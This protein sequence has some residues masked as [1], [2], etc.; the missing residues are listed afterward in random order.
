MPDRAI[1]A[2]IFD[3]QGICS[4]L[5]TFPKNR[6]STIFGGHLEFLH[7]DQ[8][9]IYLGNSGRNFSQRNFEP[10]GYLHNHLVIFPKTLFPAIFGGHLEYLRENAKTHFSRKRCQIERFQQKVLPQGICRV[11]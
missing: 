1:F 10:P 4:H 2:K 9:R 8:R 6:F 7:K 3:P 5:A 11:I